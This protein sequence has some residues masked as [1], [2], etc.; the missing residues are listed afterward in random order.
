MNNLEKN[1]Y[2]SYAPYL[3]VI[4]FILIWIKS[5]VFATDSLSFTQNRLKTALSGNIKCG[6]PYILQINAPGNEHLLRILQAQVKS[7]AQLDSLYI[8]PSGYFRIYYSI[9]GF[10]AIPAYDRND[11]GT[12]DYLEFVAKSFD[13]AWQIEIDSLGFKPP[14]DSTGENRLYYPVYCRR[15]GVYGRTYPDYE[16]PNLPGLNYVSYIELNT[17]FSF[18]QYPGIIDPIVRD[19]MA[20]AV[21]A[22]HEFNHALQCGYR[23]WFGDDDFQDSWFIESSAVYMEEVVADEVNDY[24]HYLYD[25][26]NNTRD[27]LDNSTGSYPDYGRVVL[28]IML[29]ELYGNNITRKVWEG[30]RQQRALPS[31][32]NVLNNLSSDVQT[33]INRLALWCF[34]TNE[35]AISNS[36][37]PDAT[38]FPSVNFIEGQSIT[39]APAELISDLLP[40]L[41]FQ[42]YH[43]PTETARQQNLLL[44]AEGDALASYLLSIYIDLSDGSSYFSPAATPYTLPFYLTAEGLPFSIVNGYNTGDLEFRFRLLSQPALVV[45]DEDVYVFPQPFYLSNLQPHLNFKNVPKEAQIFIYNSHGKHLITLESQIESQVIFWDLETQYGETIGS[46]VYLFKVKSENREHVGKFVVIR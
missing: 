4:Y 6:F 32:E 43:S 17:N 25:Y 31:L 45:E 26:L 30:I 42:W 12:P 2:V 34:Y 19:S 18:I 11:N 1:S 41:S 37:F 3:V 44:K 24:L 7:L 29:G 39:V 23:L 28:P 15:L 36:F 27:P 21:T 5:S 46:G 8:S 35:R 9:T 14:P 40:R 13:R 10:N 16:I 20:I 22:A 38:Y 33:E